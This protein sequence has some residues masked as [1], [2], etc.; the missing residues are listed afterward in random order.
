[1]SRSPM[2]DTIRARLYRLLFRVS[3]TFRRWH[4]H[5]LWD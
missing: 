2:R 4:F 1:M 3:A 5:R